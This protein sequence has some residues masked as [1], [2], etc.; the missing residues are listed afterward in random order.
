MNLLSK[1]GLKLHCN[2]YKFE[3]NKMCL[4]RIKFFHIIWPMEHV[5]FFFFFFS[6]PDPTTG[7]R[8]GKINKE[9]EEESK[10]KKMNK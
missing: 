2:V 4:I 6:P 9:E 1:R 10:N 7:R 8:M 3:F 5:C